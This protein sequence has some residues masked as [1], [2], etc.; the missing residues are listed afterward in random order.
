MLHAC[1]Q[2]FDVTENLK[3]FCKILVSAPST[4]PVVMHG[5]PSCSCMHGSLS[6]AVQ[7]VRMVYMDHLYRFALLVCSLASLL[8]FSATYITGY[9]ASEAPKQLLVW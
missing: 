8:T 5:G 2:R 3:K 6:C 4:R 7:P 1:V 9:S